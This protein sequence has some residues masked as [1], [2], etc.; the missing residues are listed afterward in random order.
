MD[1]CA[2]SNAQIIVATQDVKLTEFAFKEL[3]IVLTEEPVK[4][5]L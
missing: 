1:Q 4:I 2:H 5:V 3:A